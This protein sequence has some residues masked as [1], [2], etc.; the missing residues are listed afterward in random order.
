MNIKFI[1]VNKIFNKKFSFCGLGFFLDREFWKL[2][3]KD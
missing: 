3:I 1:V 2:E